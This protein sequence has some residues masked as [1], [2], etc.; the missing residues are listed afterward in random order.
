MSGKPEHDGDEPC[1]LATV[2]TPSRGHSPTTSKQPA[3]STN[4]P[5]GSAAGPRPHN[6]CTTKPGAFS[7]KATVADEAPICSVAQPC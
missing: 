4:S 2:G 3:A 1:W 5:K 6:M 7:I